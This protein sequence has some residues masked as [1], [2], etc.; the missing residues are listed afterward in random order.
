MK[1]CGQALANGNMSTNHVHS[2]QVMPLQGRMF[3]PFSISIT[4]TD[5]A[6]SPASEFTA[7][8]WVLPASSTHSTSSQ[9]PACCPDAQVSRNLHLPGPVRPIS[10]GDPPFTMSLLNSPHVS[11]RLLLSRS[12]S[13]IEGDTERGTS[14]SHQTEGWLPSGSSTEQGLWDLIMG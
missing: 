10:I 7:A 1:P 8:T 13:S 9:P 12:L 4:R 6:L 2:V 5:L 3:L 14:T 11:T